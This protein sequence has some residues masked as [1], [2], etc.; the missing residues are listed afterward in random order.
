MNKDKIIANIVL[1]LFLA[2]IT[3][4]C[5]NENVITSIH[6]AANS[7]SVCYDIINWNITGTFTKN[8]DPVLYS[9]SM[10]FPDF[11]SSYKQEKSSKKLWHQGPYTP[12]YGQLDLKEVFNIS[13]LC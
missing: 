4:S 1:I 8:E 3:C 9:T 6:I 5:S 10:H 2:I 11:S 7:D 13:I 12:K